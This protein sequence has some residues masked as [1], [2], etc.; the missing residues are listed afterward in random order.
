[1]TRTGKKLLLLEVAACFGPITGMWL[2]GVLM[3]PFMLPDALKGEF[4]ALMTMFMVIAGTG[5]L[6]ALC[7][8]VKWFFQPEGRMD[9]RWVL[10]LMVIILLPLAT[11]AIGE[12]VDQWTKMR[13][14]RRTDWWPVVMFTM[15]VLCSAHLVYLARGYLFARREAPGCIQH[16][17]A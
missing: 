1:M 17:A 16:G 10:A 12:S 7:Q 4:G 2:L 14:S 8:V 13:T 5:G 3:A 9:R 15:P 6:V 11:V